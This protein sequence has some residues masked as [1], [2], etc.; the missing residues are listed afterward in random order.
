MSGAMAKNR[1]DS[2]LSMPLAMGLLLWPCV[3]WGQS[4]QD[5][6]N[7]PPAVTD[8]LGGFT[9]ERIQA[10][11]IREARSLQPRASDWLDPDAGEEISKLLFRLR[12]L[13]TT[14][15]R[16]YQAASE[17]ITPA[18]VFAF[19]GEV[20]LIAGYKIRPEL[21]E[22]LERDGVSIIRLQTHAKSIDIATSDAPSTL[23]IGDRISGLALMIS[24][25]ETPFGVSSSIRWI[26]QNAPSPDWAA[27]GRHGVDITAI[28]VMTKRNQQGLTADDTPVFFPTLRAASDLIKSADPDDQAL[29]S[30]PQRPNAQE[31]LSKP[32]DFA[33]RWI[34][35]DVQTVR[36]TRVTITSVERQSDV[37]QDHY[38]QLDAIGDLGPVQLKLERSAGAPVVLENRYPISVVCKSLPPFLLPE[39][40][41]APALVLNTSVPVTVEGFFLRLWSYDSDLMQRNGGGKQIAP[42]LV[43]GRILDRRLREADPIGVHWIGTLAAIGV[44][45]GMMA[46]FLFHI[47]TSRTDRV[48][49][50]RR[51][52][53]VPPENIAAD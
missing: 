15:L 3:G 7:Q 40:S 24:P 33:G 39:S 31:L 10:I 35:L 53:S 28:G 46:V 36:I 11:R 8:L 9:A 21:A 12:K 20:S 25:D 41:T 13:S 27:L 38:F 50:K 52:D 22:Y 19:D 23:Q 48:A 29:R 6:D 30:E 34:S 4:S 14:T 17:T 45:G 42:L 37:G 47:R 26:P 2:L 32:T 1:A 43:A 18:S 49:R 51:H 5:N 16:R 44:V